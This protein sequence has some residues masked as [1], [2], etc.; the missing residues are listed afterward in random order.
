MR[1]KI[2]IRYVN[3]FLLHKYNFVNNKSKKLFIDTQFLFYYIINKIKIQRNR[4]DKI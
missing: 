4:R 2:F 1:N 3:N